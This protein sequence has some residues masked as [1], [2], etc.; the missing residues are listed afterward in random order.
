MT[1]IAD[2]KLA[3]RI[4]EILI[5]NQRTETLLEYITLAWEQ[6]PILKKID[7]ANIQT[8]DYLNKTNKG[9]NENIIKFNTYFTTR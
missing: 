1:K 3:R 7:I 9:K 4:L 8:E 2:H 6:K 5:K